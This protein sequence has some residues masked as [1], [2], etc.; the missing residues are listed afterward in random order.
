MLYSRLY[1]FK[2]ISA[3]KTTNPPTSSVRNAP[4]GADSVV[5][6]APNGY[7][8]VNH[9]EMLLGQIEA[10]FTNEIEQTVFEDQTRAVFGTKV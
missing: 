10:L 9:Y 7:G 6:A 3:S 4:P 8:I 1:L 2:T 5:T